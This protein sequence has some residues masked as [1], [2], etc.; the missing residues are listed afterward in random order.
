MLVDKIDR[1]GVDCDIDIQKTIQN[2]RSQRSG[3]VQTEAQYKFIYMAVSQ[4]IE[5]TQKKIQIIGE[6][7][8]T[9][10]EY[11]NIQYPAQQKAQHSK[12]SRKTSNHTEDP[13]LYE[14]VSKA[15]KDE[16][17]RKQ[18]SEEREK[19]GK[20]KAGSVKKK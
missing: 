11:G 5:T 19:G 3:L 9:E 16:R 13:L 1:Q 20:L 15:K 17:V 8:Q 18:R 6:C 2:V 7:K 12:V 10:S 14:N 4:Y